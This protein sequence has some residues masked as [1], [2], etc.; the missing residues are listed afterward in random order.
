MSDLDVRRL[1]KALDDVQATL[2]GLQHQIVARI[3]CA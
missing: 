3:R 1:A 2:T